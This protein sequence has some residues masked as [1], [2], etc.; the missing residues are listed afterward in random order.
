M[1]SGTG[2]TICDNEDGFHV[3]MS[4]ITLVMKTIKRALQAGLSWSG[5][6]Y[7]YIQRSHIPSI[8]SLLFDTNIQWIN[9]F[10]ARSKYCTI[11][12]CFVLYYITLYCTVVRYIVLYSTKL[13]CIVLYYLTLYCAVLNNSVF[14]YTIL[15]CFVLYYITF[16][17][18]FLYKIAMYCAILYCIVLYYI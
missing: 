4:L 7:Q 11:L 12:H 8:I 15:H 16:Y 6:L 5:Q 10:I 2:W 1:K 9:L 17:C 3:H 13:P 18:T 14:Y